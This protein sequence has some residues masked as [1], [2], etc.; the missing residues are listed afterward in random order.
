MG[1]YY[2]FHKF[3]LIVLQTY[4]RKNMAPV[5]NELHSCLGSRCSLQLQEISASAKVPLWGIS[6]CQHRPLWHA[7]HHE[8]VEDRSSWGCAPSPSPL[9][10]TDPLVPCKQVLNNYLES[11]WES[12]RRENSHYPSLPSQCPCS[13]PN[14]I[15]SYWFTYLKME[16][17]VYLRELNNLTHQKVPRTGKS[18]MDISYYNYFKMAN[19]T[20]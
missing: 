3:D 13:N 14:V 18:S 6:S 8:A 4:T 17:I 1:G 10:I 15:L 19:A 7:P 11:H 2:K 12:Q 9:Y 16:I 5:Q 20:H